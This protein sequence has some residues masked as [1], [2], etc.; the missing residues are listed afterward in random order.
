MRKLFQRFINWLFHRDERIQS[1]LN[2][3]TRYYMK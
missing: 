1:N 3:V 2:I